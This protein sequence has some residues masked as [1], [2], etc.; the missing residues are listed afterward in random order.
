MRLRGAPLCLLLLLAIG[1]DPRVEE[2][3]GLVRVINKAQDDLDGLHGQ[4]DA[5]GIRKFAEELDVVVEKL[6]AVA[7]KL[8]DLRGF[9]D[10]Y[11][12]LIVDYSKDLRSLAEAQESGDVAKLQATATDGNRIEKD[13]TELI[14]AINTYCGGK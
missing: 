4:A 8:A 13:S 6:D 10:R 2:C 14:A 7:L 9:R 5:S 12:T 1:C 3:N 11:R